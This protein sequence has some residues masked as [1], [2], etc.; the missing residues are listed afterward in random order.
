MGKS[1]QRDETF[2]EKNIPSL[3]Y[4][5]SIMSSN[6]TPIDI[7]NMPDLLGL[8]K[9]V[10]ATH[11]PRELK[12][13]DKIVAVLSPVLEDEKNVEVSNM[14][15]QKSLAAIGSWS[16]QGFQGDHPQPIDSAWLAPLGIR[17]RAPKM[18]ASA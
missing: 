5:A 7:S 17:L 10:E 11:K 3:W 9:E 12:R 15:Y 2:R 4:N 13:D 16:D 1:Q 8:V 18:P 6:L 14:A